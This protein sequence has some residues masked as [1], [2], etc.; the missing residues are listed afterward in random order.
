[1]VNPGGQEALIEVPIE[2]FI[3]MFINERPEG[4][5]PIRRNGGKGRTAKVANKIKLI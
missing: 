5:K 3:N 2:V 1:M 4:H